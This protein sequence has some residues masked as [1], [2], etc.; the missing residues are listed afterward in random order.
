MVI[1]TVTSAF[2]RSN[3]ILTLITK[4]KM[5]LKIPSLTIHSL[6]LTLPFYLF[7]FAL[8]ERRFFIKSKDQHF[9]CLSFVLVWIPDHP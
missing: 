2:I 5:R 3:T 9:S 4:Y 1:A 6:S 7:Y 8:V